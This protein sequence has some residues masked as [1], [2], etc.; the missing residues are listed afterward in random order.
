MQRARKKSRKGPKKDRERL[1]IWQNVDSKGGE[2]D[3][4]LQNLQ[5]QKYEKTSVRQMVKNAGTCFTAGVFNR[6]NSYVTT[7][8]WNL[9]NVLYML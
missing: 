9:S 6:Y 2:S 3:E 4:N 7:I 5:R 8:V 1:G